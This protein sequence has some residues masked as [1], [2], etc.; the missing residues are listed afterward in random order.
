MILVFYI[1]SN[2]GGG[3]GR[4][5]GDWPRA[6]GPVEDTGH[7]GYLAFRPTGCNSGG[8]RAAWDQ[9]PLAVMTGLQQAL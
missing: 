8:T 5:M 6:S 2:G 7:R 3:H 9:V 1:S 4:G